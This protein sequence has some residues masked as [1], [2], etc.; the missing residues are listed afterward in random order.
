[1]LPQGSYSRA[2][3]IRDYE[4]E[5]QKISNWTEGQLGSHY[6]FHTFDRKK[7]DLQ[8]RLDWVRNENKEKQ[9]NYIEPKNKHG[10]NL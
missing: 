2:Y 5:G 9:T 7:L 10:F 4:V 8:G 6:Y 3:L 1:V